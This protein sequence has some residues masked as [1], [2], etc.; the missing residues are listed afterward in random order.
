MRRAVDLAGLPESAGSRSSCSLQLHAFL[1]AMAVGDVVLTRDEHHVHVGVV[2]GPA[3]NVRPTG[4]DPY[5]RRRPV[6]WVGVL[7]RAEFDAETALRS[8]VM[9]VSKH[10]AVLAAAVAPLLERA[11]L[12]GPPAAAPLAD[13]PPAEEPPTDAPHAVPYRTADEAVTPAR[14]EPSAADPAAVA[15]ANQVHAALQNALRDE[16]ERHV[17]TVWS[18]RPD[19]PDLQYDL[20]WRDAGLVSVCEVKSLGGGSHAERM[21]AAVGQVLDYAQRLRAYEAQVRPVVWVERKPR[22]ADHWKRVCAGAGVVLAWP[23][24]EHRVFGARR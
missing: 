11:G 14:A 17:L 9:R 2:T 20:A 23:G 12:P 5:W 4:A 16:A 8:T 21:R 6:D 7:P 1:S 10:R 15:R 18:P 19:R 22:E 13:G 24:K 3:V